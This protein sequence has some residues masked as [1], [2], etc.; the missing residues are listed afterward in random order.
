MVG[1]LTKPLSSYRT[2]GGPVAG[3]KWAQ[4]TLGLEFEVGGFYLAGINRRGRYMAFHRLSD[5]DG[6][7]EVDWAEMTERFIVNKAR[8]VYALVGW[9]TT[10][11]TN[12]MRGI[13]RLEWL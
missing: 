6:V 8:D 5:I 12:A 3:V 1:K 9:D 2:L 13:G 11:L 7:D 10:A 4:D